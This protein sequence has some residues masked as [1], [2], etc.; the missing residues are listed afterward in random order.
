MEKTETEKKMEQILKDEK[1]QLL[2]EI[3]NIVKK[4]QAL[5]SK[6]DEVSYRKRR[7]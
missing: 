2:S 4:K 6:S 7:Y 1:E 5:A 3:S